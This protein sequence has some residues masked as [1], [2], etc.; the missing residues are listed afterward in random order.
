M[1]IER[2]GELAPLERLCLTLGGIFLTESII[3][4]DLITPR[5]NSKGG[6]FNICLIGIIVILVMKSW[7]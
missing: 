7:S 4:F 2:V 3:P 1:R 6:D 5:V